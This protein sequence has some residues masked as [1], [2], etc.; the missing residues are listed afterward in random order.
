MEITRAQFAQMTI[1]RGLSSVRAQTPPPSGED[2]KL[3]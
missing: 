1:A 3:I 2:L